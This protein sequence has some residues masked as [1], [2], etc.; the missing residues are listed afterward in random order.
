ME[1]YLT[2]DLTGE[3]LWFTTPYRNRE[4]HVWES[5]HETPENKIPVVNGTLEFFCWEAVNLAFP[6][7]IYKLSGLELKEVKKYAIA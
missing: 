5:E 3:Y 6:P 4:K 2:W 7:C 1:C